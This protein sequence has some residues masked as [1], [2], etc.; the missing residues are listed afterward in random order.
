MIKFKITYVLLKNFR[1]MTLPTNFIIFYIKFLAIHR[2][3]ASIQAY[4]LEDHAVISQSQQQQNWHL[5]RQ[6]DS[7]IE[8]D[9]VNVLYCVLCT[10]LHLPCTYALIF[11]AIN[12]SPFQLFNVAILNCLCLQYWHQYWILCASSTDNYP[13]KKLRNASKNKFQRPKQNS[14]P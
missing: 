8:I 1:R 3:I 6:V 10:I 4:D 13:G 11:C 14:S 2:L 7:K 9:C 12:I 5:H